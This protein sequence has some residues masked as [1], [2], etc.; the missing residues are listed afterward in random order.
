[1]TVTLTS[2]RCD[3]KNTLIAEWD[4]FDLIPLGLGQFELAL[5]REC[6][7]SD[8]MADKLL[9]LEMLVR[10]YEHYRANEAKR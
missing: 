6:D 7:A 2:N 9:A 4:E 10:K 1:M 8:S 3:F 5:L